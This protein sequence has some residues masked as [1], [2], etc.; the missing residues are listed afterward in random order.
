M[1][2]VCLKIGQP[3]KV[4]V[5]DKNI[6]HISYPHEIQTIPIASHWISILTVELTT[7]WW[8]GTWILFSISYMGCHPSHWRAYFSR[9]LLHHQPDNFWG[10]FSWSHRTWSNWLNGLRILRPC[11]PCSSDGPKS[12]S[13]A[14]RCCR[15]TWRKMLGMA[16]GCRFRL[17]MDWLN[18]KSTGNHRFCYEIWVFPVIFPLNQ[19][20]EV[21]S[22]DIATT[23]EVISCYIPMQLRLLMD[24]YITHGSFT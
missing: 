21:R 19:S 4:A 17:S 9:W 23:L 11:I 12:W 15:D 5:S 1:I 14:A 10:V 18:C 24:I 22:G 20:I 2:W 7:G 3:A 13:L 6:A 8:F 16:G